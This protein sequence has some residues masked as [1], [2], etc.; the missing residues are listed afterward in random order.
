MERGTGQ[1]TCYTLFPFS[2]RTLNSWNCG[3]RLF[4]NLEDTRSISVQLRV[5]R[6]YSFQTYTRVCFVELIVDVADIAAVIIIVILGADRV[7][8]VSIIR[9]KTK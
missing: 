5:K 7:E 6:T 3:I 2:S 4:K 8:N 1:G 9:V